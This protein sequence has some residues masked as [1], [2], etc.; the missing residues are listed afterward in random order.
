MTINEKKRQ[1]A[2]KRLVQANES[3]DE[4]RYLFDGSKSPRVI[5]EALL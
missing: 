5:I 2:S 4:A 3:L 1:L